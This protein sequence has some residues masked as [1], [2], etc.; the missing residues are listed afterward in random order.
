MAI[1]PC[2]HS[3][4]VDCFACAQSGCPEC[5]EELLQEN[6]GLIW[7]VVQMQ[8]I[9]KAAYAD[10][11]QEGWIG[12]W[13]A[14]MHFDPGRGVAFSHYAWRA[15]RNRVWNAVG[16]SLKSEGWLESAS[17]RDSLTLIVSAWQEQQVR[18]A[19]QDELDCLPE[20][21]RQVIALHYGLG[22]RPPLLLKEIGQQLKVSGERV[23]QLRNDALVLLRLPALSMRLRSL[24]EQDSRQAYQQARHLNRAWQRNQ[25]RR[26]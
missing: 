12:L 20:R 13:Q 17:S 22:G 3:Q 9:G 6:G 11:I 26:P 2:C 4:G 23:R 16:Q 18:Q 10:L 5:L 7:S 1:V 15:I 21:L 14:V 25:R 24:C 19:L 8:G